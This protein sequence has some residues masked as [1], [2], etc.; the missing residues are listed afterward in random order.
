MEHRKSF[1]FQNIDVR[2]IEYMPFD[3]NKWNSSKLVPYA[4]MLEIVKGH[5]P[6]IERLNDSVNDTSKVLL[7]RN[8]I[9]LPQGN[10]KILDLYEFRPTKCQVSKAEWVSSRQ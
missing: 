4:K 5:F 8:D 10:I 2:F 3:G 7:L 9:E 6:E 1:I